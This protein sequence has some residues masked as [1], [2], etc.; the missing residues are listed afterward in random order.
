[1]GQSDARWEKMTVVPVGCAGK[2]FPAPMLI[3]IQQGLAAPLF[4]F[5]ILPLFSPSTKVRKPHICT[6]FTVIYLG[7]PMMRPV[8]WRNSVDK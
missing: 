6:P 5:A 7:L 8:P 1:M 2:S 3:N 4:K